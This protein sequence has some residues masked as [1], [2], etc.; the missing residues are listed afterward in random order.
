[1][2]E[3]SFDNN[4]LDYDTLLANCRNYELV[5]VGSIALE[6]DFDQYLQL[7]DACQC[8]VVVYHAHEN[9]VDFNYADILERPI[10]AEFHKETYLHD[11]GIYPMSHAIREKNFLPFSKEKKY[12]VSAI[13]GVAKGASPSHYKRKLLVDVIS[14]YFPD[15]IAEYDATMSYQEFCQKTSESWI[16]I[17]T[18]GIGYQTSRYYEI[19]AYGAMLVSER[20]PVVI[21]DD[22]NMNDY[23]RFDYRFDDGI[24]EQIVLHE[25]VELLYGLLGDKDE[26]CRKIES[27]RAHLRQFHSPEALAA[28]FMRIVSER[29]ADVRPLAY[30]R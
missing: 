28:R 9:P 24:P 1:M 3:Y 11:D 25:L 22:F 8:P 12:D 23:A 13:F 14:D 26:L 7:I 2:I 18:R 19:P 29:M 5:I 30:S 21:P 20:M 10:L 27:S 15:S 6:D 17:S 4:D 16:G